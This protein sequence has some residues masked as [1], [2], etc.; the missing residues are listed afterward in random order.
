MT[1]PLPIPELSPLDQIRMAEAEVTR[2][3]VAARE[4]SRRVSAEAGAQAS[5]LKKEAHDSGT[6]QGQIRRKVIVANAEEEARAIVARAREGASA[7]KRRGQARMEEAIREAMNIV[8]GPKGSG[9][10]NES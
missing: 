10:L 5:L 1:E 6:Q 9:D 3:L 2:K 7:L 4:T 8:L